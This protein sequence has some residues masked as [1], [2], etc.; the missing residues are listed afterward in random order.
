MDQENNCEY[1]CSRG[2]LK[3]CD[4]NSTTPISSVQQLI[5]Y[6][7]SAL[8]PGCT[9]YVCGSAVPNF[10]SDFAHKILCPYTLVSGDCDTTIPY[11]IFS[12]H[13]FLEFINSPNLIHWFSQNCVLTT[14]PKL[15]QIPIGLDYHTMSE[16]DHE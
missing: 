4:V 15:S 7:F 13:K 16:N 6:D 14:H 2:I 10:I 5:N 11:D 1:V 12:E 8:R 9:I 3:S